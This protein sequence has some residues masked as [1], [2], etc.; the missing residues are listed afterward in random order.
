MIDINLISYF[1][2]VLTGFG[3]V[4]GFKVCSGK[5]EKLGEFEYAAFSTI[6]G[7]LIFLPIFLMFSAHTGVV[8]IIGAF[9]FIATPILFVWGV[10]V[11][12]IAAR[13]KRCIPKLWQRLTK[14]RR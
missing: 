9:P 7:S 5:K 14:A 8:S 10:I 11:G 12:F 6:W 4:W 13:L 2:I 1:L 3:A